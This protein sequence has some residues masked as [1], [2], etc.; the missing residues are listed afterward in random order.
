MYFHGGRRGPVYAL[1][2]IIAHVGV[3]TSEKLGVMGLPPK[4]LSVLTHLCYCIVV[5][6]VNFIYFIYFFFLVFSVF[7]IP[8]FSLS[9]YC[10]VFV[11]MQMIRRQ[12]PL[13]PSSGATPE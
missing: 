10:F 3:Q 8:L 5:I 7:S 12:Q 13:L 9:F 2:Q 6:L 1:T 11:F 4:N